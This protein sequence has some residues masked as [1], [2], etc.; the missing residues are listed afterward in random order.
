MPHIIRT[1]EDIFRAEKRDIYALHWLD[2]GD[3]IE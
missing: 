3:D 1:P 2:N